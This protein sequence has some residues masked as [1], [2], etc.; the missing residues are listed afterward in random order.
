M[1]SCE[2]NAYISFIHLSF[3]NRRVLT[4]PEIIFEDQMAL[5]LEVSTTKGNHA[6]H[7][8]DAD[9]TKSSHNSIETD[10]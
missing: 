4:M 8:R 2:R 7:I 3:M 9:S 5:N 1:I 6:M 10:R